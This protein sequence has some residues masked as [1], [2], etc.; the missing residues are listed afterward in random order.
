MQALD[1]INFYPSLCSGGDGGAGGGGT[2]PFLSDQEVEIM[3]KTMEPEVRKTASTSGRAAESLVLNHNTHCQ[4]FS[5]RLLVSE[6][7]ETSGDRQGFPVLATVCRTVP[8]ASF[9]SFPLWPPRLS[10]EDL[11]E[12]RAEGQSSGR[13]KAPARVSG[14]LVS[15]LRP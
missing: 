5:K 10:W 14:F 6:C 11:T 9:H 3:N 13:G 15:H 7:G 12:Q 4:A 2:R 1:V 8:R